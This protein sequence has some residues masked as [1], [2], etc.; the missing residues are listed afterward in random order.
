MDPMKTGKEPLYLLMFL[1]LAVLW[2]GSFINIKIVV[3]A[4]PPLFSAGIR[5]FIAFVCLTFLFLCRKKKIR[6][7]FKDASRL[8]LTGIFNQGLPFALLFYGERSVNPALA[9]ILNSTVSIWVLLLG[10]IAFCNFSQWT[11]NKIIGLL[12][13]SAGVIF[14]F[15]PLLN[16][17]T[18]IGTLSITGMAIAYAIGALLNQHLIFGK[19]TTSLEANLWQQHISSVV[20]LMVISFCVEPRP[21]YSHFMHLNIIGAFLYL[22][23]FATALAWMIYFS[24]L[25][26]WDAVRASSVMYVVPLLA[27]LWDYLFLHLIP[28]WN[29]AAGAAAILGGIIMIQWKRPLKKTAS[30]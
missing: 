8:W 9:S 25:K 4:F 1:L 22:G 2:S 10:T 18:L 29:E 13:G 6:V 11:P 17:S 20:F 14:I 15:Y 21:L 28:S 27:I 26:H 16:A 24:L 19:M 7:S 12:L 5:V 23:V 30:V 3:E